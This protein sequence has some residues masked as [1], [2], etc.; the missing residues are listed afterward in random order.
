MTR[1]ELKEM[2]KDILTEELKRIDEAKLTEAPDHTLLASKL[3]DTHAFTEA[4]MTN[5]LAAVKR[6]VDE[7]MESNDMY[8]PGAQKLKADILRMC[9]RSGARTGENILSFVWN[10]RLSGTGD[11]VIKVG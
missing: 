10:S 4:C 8:T 5:D 9:A 11:K 3:A 1:S 7:V 2:I 6:I